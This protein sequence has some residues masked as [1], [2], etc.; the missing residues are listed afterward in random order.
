MNESACRYRFGEYSLIPARRELTHAGRRLS[1]QPKVFDTLAYLLWHRDR[2]VGRDELVAAVW[3]RV[4]VSDNVLSQ[5]VGRARQAVGDSGEEQQA[6]FTLPRF[7]Y[8]WVREVEVTPAIAEPTADSAPPLRRHR[9]LATAALA[10]LGLAAIAAIAFVAA[11]GPRDGSA[12]ASLD[13]ADLADAPVRDR[14]A[15]LRRALALDQLDPA[16]AIYRTFADQDRIDPAVRDA[17]AMLAL[18]E[19]RADEALAAFTALLADLG[20]HGDRLQ[21]GQALY[22]AG[23]AAARSDHKDD[24]QRYYEQAI[25]A[26]DALTA[27]EARAVR[28]RAWTSL[29]RLLFDRG[30]LDA[31][32]HAYTQAGA[33]LEGTGDRAA[34]AQ[35]ESN[36]G[37]LLIGRYRHGEALPRFE[38]AAAL[39]AQADD[40]SG[41]ARA[42]MNLANVQ[43]VLLQPA[44]ALA[45]EPRLRALRERIGDPWLA[46][47][48]DLVRARVLIANGR[49]SDADVVLQGHAGRPNPA[50]PALTAFRD[51]VAAELAFARGALDAGSDHATA[52]LASPW[53]APENGLAA[54]ARY[55]LLMARQALGDAAGLADVAAAA[56]AQRRERPAEPMVRLY[57]MLAQGE[58]AAATGD[59]AAARADFAQAL[60]QAETNGVPFD[61]VQAADAYARFLVQHGAT[62]E[63]GPL[64]GR[65]AAWAEHDYGASLAQLAVYHAAGDDAWQPVL[66]RTQR[67]AGERV[68]PP[69]L[70]T[71][72]VGVGAAGE[73]VLVAGHGL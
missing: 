60:A 50:E 61:L 41:E 37:V 38:R 69:A 64:A 68:I 52:A 25:G 49:L 32:E 36:T 10:V 46:G 34:L 8:Q 30:A 14:V 29:G 65:L 35:W 5:I 22:G 13:P 19:G 11:G 55:R 4:D 9:L 57:A 24:A 1:V 51:V 66:E 33:A 54:Y 16:R 27:P 56:D 2:A 12:V 26:L 20:E 70:T 18:Q 72:P 31:A 7:G 58:A 63:A 3:G 39:A 48:V 53:Y 42:R 17:A 71:R 15:A 73:R 59:L 44:A 47:N 45:S 23:R 28:G 21:V 62:A 67:L 6:I 40:V 43:L